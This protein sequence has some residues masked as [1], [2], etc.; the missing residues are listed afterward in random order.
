MIGRRPRHRLD[1]GRSPFT[2]GLLT[3]LAVAVG[4]YFGFTKANPFATPF[5][6]KAAFRSATDI[7]AK[8]P[9]RIAGVNV[10]KVTKVERLPGDSA[11]ALVTMEIQDKGLP[12]HRDAEVKVRPRIFLEGNFFVEVSPGSPSA[13]KLGDGDTIPVNQTAAPVQLGSVLEALQGDTRED[14]QILLQEY[15]KG[16]S[17][18]GARGY[19]RSIRHWEP[20]YRDGAIVNEATL[21]ILE[22]DL[23]RYVDG[24]GAVAAALD[25]D[26]LALKDLITNFATTAGA[27]QSEQDN[28]RTAIGILDDTLVV[29]RRALG[30]LNL[31]LPPLR[32]LAA[33]LRPAVRS[34]GP[35]LD[36]TLPFV[37]EARGLFRGAELGG[38]A[39]DLRAVVPDLVE[40][41]VGGLTF[42]EQ[43]RLLSSCNVNVIQKVA[44]DK[45]EDANFPSSG[46][47]YQE[48]VKWLPGISGESRSAD[49]NGPY[50]KTTAKGGANFAYSLGA[51]RF[52]LTGAP[53]GGVNP[54]AR[55][56]ESP[57]RP[58]VP[59]ETQDPPNLQSI[60]DPAPPAIR[61]ATSGTAYQ[62]R[63][64]KAQARAISWLTDQV[65]LEGLSG[66]L[67][68]SK[69]PL[70]RSALKGG[71]K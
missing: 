61:A 59:C 22:H 37:K 50:I 27:F 58:D 25:R 62:E 1:P 3:L 71:G 44:E 33:D 48:G 7:K 69:T 39:K 67:R 9:V 38:L 28:L 42:Q 54:P 20:A 41:N 12:I 60:P 35:A 4:T 65:K 23:S 2:V 55:K 46:K 16:L 13:P 21:G 8:S 31:A 45:I 43:A 24:A 47:V 40:L 56:T 34:S 17:G 19:R 57:L 29:G 36:A 30:E 64:A 14:L 49:A 63:L 53:L 6:L 68:V 32:R 70:T 15:G 52:L 10:G 66:K 5:E 26:P 18:A 51:G 11:G